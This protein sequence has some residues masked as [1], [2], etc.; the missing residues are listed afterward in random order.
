MNGVTWS[1]KLFRSMFGGT[2]KC[3]KGQ[4][5]LQEGRHAGSAFGMPEHRLDGTNVNA[6]TGRSGGKFFTE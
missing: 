2:M 5:C 4:R 1:L 6:F 3:W